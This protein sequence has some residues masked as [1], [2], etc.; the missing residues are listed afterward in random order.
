[1]R[2][3]MATVKKKIWPEYFKAVISGKKKYE[4]RLNDFAVKEDDSLLLEEW[5]PKT[6]KYTG[7]K[8]EKKVTYVGK[9]KMDKQLFWPKE[10]TKEK[11]IQIISLE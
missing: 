4:L 10:E 11:G 8:V 5:D 9:F 3:S 2:N 1:M 6:K 7:R